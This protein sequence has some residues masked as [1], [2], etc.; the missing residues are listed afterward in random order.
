MG[1]C[2][3][4]CFEIRDKNNNSRYIIIDSKTLLIRFVRVLLLYLLCSFFLAFLPTKS[5]R[6]KEVFS[7]TQQTIRTTAMTSTTPPPP[8][9]RGVRDCDDDE[10]DEEE[11]NKSSSSSAAPPRGGG[12]TIGWR[13][14]V[15][16]LLA[17]WRRRQNALAS[18]QKCLG[19]WT[20]AGVR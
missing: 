9:R 1:E 6:T 8:S 17:R 5:K 13:R 15:V 19:C 11:Q 7:H 18:R 2:V 4:L 16:F 20:I 10:D 12:A 3:V 14:F